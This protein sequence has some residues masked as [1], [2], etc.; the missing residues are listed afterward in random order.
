MLR[1]RLLPV[2]IVIVS[3]A[4]LTAPAAAQGN[5]SG[6]NGNNGNGN[7]NGGSGGEPGDSG[8]VVIQCEIGCLPT[9]PQPTILSETFPTTAGVDSSG[10]STITVK[11]T[12]T[13][14]GLF[15]FSC[16]STSSQL[17]CDGLSES[18]FWLNKGAQ[19][20]ITVDWS[21][22]GNGAFTLL[23]ELFAEANSSIDSLDVD[24]TISGPSFIV[25]A[26]P[27]PNGERTHEA[28]LAHFTRAVTTSTVKLW[29]NGLL[30]SGASVTSSGYTK[31]PTGLGSGTHTW[32]TEAC[33]ASGRCDTYSTSF[34]QIG[35]SAW[36]LDDSLPPAQGHGIEGLLGG[37]PLPDLGLRGCPMEPGYPEIR[38]VAPTSFLSQ[39]GSGGY[40]AGLVFAASVSM[41]GDLDI[42]TL[43]VD[44]LASDPTTCEDYGYLARSDF[45][46]SFWAGSDS[47][48]VL[49]DAW[50]TART[51]RWRSGGSASGSTSSHSVVAKSCAAHSSG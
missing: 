11:N 50:P 41:N 18:S 28:L 15:S 34:A 14:G 6:G 39:P 29:L 51:D 21:S 5:G 2:L 17:L 30:Q 10:E 46:W 43:T 12:G 33:T 31:T 13:A 48:D 49:W 20:V 32:K 19:K 25:H 16:G 9:G 7:G 22:R 24:I 37:L 40:P 36:Q 8:G 3:L 42:S 26:I 38:L 23:F 35:A 27:F 45:N 1:A 47:T 4:I 44:R